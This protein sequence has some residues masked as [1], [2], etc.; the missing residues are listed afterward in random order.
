VALQTTAVARQWLSSD[1]RHECNNKVTVR[2]RDF[3][4]FHRHNMYTH[5]FL[6]YFP[7]SEKIKGGLWVRHTICSSMYPPLL[8][9]IG[10][11]GVDRDQC[12]ALVN[13]AL[14]PRVL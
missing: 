12:R 9:D 7:Y 13:T 1:N 11:D 6:A 10:W 5:T 3:Y 8:R 4:A 2:S 14:N